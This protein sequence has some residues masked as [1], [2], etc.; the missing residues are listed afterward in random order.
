MP[1]KT[2]CE[3]FAGV[4]LVGEGL[5]PGGWSCV[6]ANDCDAHKRVMFRARG[7]NDAAFHLGD[8]HDTASVVARIP[9]RPLLATA[10]FPCTDL[11][12][13]GNFRGFAG[14]ESSTF[15]GF[16]AALDALR[17]RRPPLVMLENVLGFLSARNGDDFRAVAGTLAGLGYALD[18]FVL[19][20]AWFTPQSRPR[21]FV[22]GTMEHRSAAKYGLGSSSR[23][24][25]GGR[26]SQATLLSGEAAS[27]LRPPRL[28][29]LIESTPL[30]TGWRLRNLPAPPERTLRLVDCLDVDDAQEWWSAKETARHEA[31]LSDLHKRRVA[32]HLAAGEPFVATG[33]RRIRA[34]V[35]R[36]ELRFDGLAGCLRTP[37]GG[38]AR[39]I[40]A[41]GVDGRLRLRWMTPREYARLQGA[42]D[43]VLDLPT[44]RQLW[45]YA[46]AVCVP[47]IAWID[48]MVLSPL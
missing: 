19:D 31:M 47:A 1:A 3:F 13:A 21:V 7:G 24:P 45:G 16:A 42:A 36:L 29:A 18:A 27:P 37:R 23:S 46:D 11:S 9:E 30:P 10:S 20:A 15:F 41:A 17:E 25:S 14:K 32:E 2:F 35:Q 22:V 43:P 6:Y 34:E 40:V 26:R 5:R 33:F 44:S 38:S 28:A 39:Q 8:V 4:G 48:R 12:L